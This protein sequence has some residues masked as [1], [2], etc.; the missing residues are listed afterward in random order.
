M[1]T[2]AFL[3]SCQFCEGDPLGGACRVSHSSSWVRRT[4]VEF[5]LLP[6]RYRFERS[7][8]SEY[9]GMDAAY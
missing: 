1:A 9:S 7:S 4:F 3:E 5:G 6:G 8:Q 2:P